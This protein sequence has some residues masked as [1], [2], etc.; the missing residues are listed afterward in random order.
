MERRAEI[1]AAMHSLL[2]SNRR[3]DPRTPVGGPIPITVPASAPPAN[4][5]L[6]LSEPQLRLLRGLQS[7]LQE[8]GIEAELT[9]IIHAIIV[10]LSARPSLCRG[11]LAAYLLEG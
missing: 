7:V 6:A 5:P 2:S 11:L 9:E 3:P 4:N 1:R 8:N 10:V